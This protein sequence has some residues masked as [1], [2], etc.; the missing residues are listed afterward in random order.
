MPEPPNAKITAFV[1]SGRRRLYV[2][3]GR[4]KLSAGNSSC[5]AMITPTS[6]PTM[7]HTTVIN[8]KLRTTPSLKSTRAVLA[9]WAA[10]SPACTCPPGIAAACPNW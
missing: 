7:P 10:E 9:E 4:S 1:C 8:A 3:Q 6:I 5:E 2:S